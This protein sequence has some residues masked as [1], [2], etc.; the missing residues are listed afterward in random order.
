MS[1]VQNAKV[2]LRVIDSHTG[3]EPTRTLIEG[4]PDLGEG[5]VKERL[6]RF[7]DK[8]DHYRTA[9]IAEPRSSDVA[10]GALL[11]EPSDPTCHFGLAF[12]NP[13][14][15]LGMCGHG[16]IGVMETLAHLDR[17]PGKEV[18]FETPVGVVK[19]EYLSDGKVRLQ[20][21]A[22]RRTLTKVQLSDCTGDVAYGGNW[23]FLTYDHG[24]RV[25][26][27]NIQRLTE[28]AWAIRR[29][30]AEKGVTGDSGEEI[31]HVELFGPSE[32]AHSRNFVLCPGGA[33]DRSP[34]GTGTSAKVACLAADGTFP[35]YSEL[36][37]ESI[38]GSV[39][40]ASYSIIDG[41]VIPSITGK[42]YVCADVTIIIDL[43]D[44]FT[45]GI[46]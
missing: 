10:V 31:D 12:F 7:A 28:R 3:G 20:N 6:E 22:S 16:T 38:I 21:V 11:M 27:D 15:Y 18:R 42:A 29:E 19:A 35:D 44:P 45:W 30:L 8:F 34:C 9:I 37:Q 39:F 23:F 40:S 36:Q 25:E 26:K 41:Q 24:E 4:L 46:R 43:H 14:G 32:Y 2:P 33:Y 13:A 5:T 1:N 17:L